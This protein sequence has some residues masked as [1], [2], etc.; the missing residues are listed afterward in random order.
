MLI[1]EL[2]TYLEIKTRALAVELNHEIQTREAHGTTQVGDGDVLEIVT[3]VGG[4]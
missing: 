2:L 3:L 4:G 1:S